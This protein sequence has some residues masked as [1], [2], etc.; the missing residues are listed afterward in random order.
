MDTKGQTRQ[1]TDINVIPN[2]PTCYPGET[3]KT[4]LQILIS[5]EVVA[6]SHGITS[7]V[8]HGQRFPH[9]L[10]FGKERALIADTPEV[11]PK[12]MKNY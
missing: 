8:V 6:R 11:S 1:P 10:E 5:I 4:M 9:W 12:T 3:V 2:D 7:S